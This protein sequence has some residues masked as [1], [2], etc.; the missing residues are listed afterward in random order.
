M[1]GLLKQHCFSAGHVKK[2]FVS[3]FEALLKSSQNIEDRL[4]DK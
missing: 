4:W 3:L 2:N 1:K